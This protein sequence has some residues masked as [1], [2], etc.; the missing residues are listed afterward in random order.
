MN[1][2]THVFAVA[3]ENY[4]D[5]TIRQVTFAENDA[6]KFVE[7]WHALGADTKDC[8]LLLSTKATFKSFETRLKAFLS[9]V[10]TGDRVV[11]FFAGHGLAINAESRITVHDTD[12]SDLP[13]TTIPLSDI[14]KQ[15]RA[16]PSGQVL[17]FLDSCHS[18]LPINAGMRS[19]CSS[20]SADELDAFCKDSEYHFAFASCK[21]DQ[22]S[23][24]TS[25]LSHGIWSYC[26]LSALKG[27]VKAALE[28]GSLVTGNS[29]QT[30]VADEVPRILRKT[31]AGAVSQTPCAFGNHTKEFVVAD[32]GQILAAKAAKASTLGSLLKD[33]VLRGVAGGGVRSLT[34]FRKG[35]HREPDGHFRAAEKFVRDVGHEDV[36]SQ[37]E[38]MATAI[39]S[40][41]GY[42]FKDVD[43]ACN[44]GAA[45]I[46]TPDFDVN[47]WIQQAEDDAA[48]YVL[49]TD[50]SAIRNQA[51]V[52]EDNFSNVFSRY[53]DTVVIELSK[54]IGVVEKIGQIEDIKELN[55]HL[56]PKPDGSSFT[57]EL[58]SH[59]I[60]LHVTERQIMITRLSGGN[61]K[62]LLTKAQKGLIALGGA[63]V[64]L[65]LPAPNK[66]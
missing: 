48:A 33:S 56:D 18:G 41:F 63:G 39:K 61:L 9:H 3:V 38:E 62:T 47:L 36:K 6:T 42:K 12:R 31:I 14:L 43:F 13:G 11:F 10:A 37:A 2:R 19:I 53:C 35:S 32:V 57:L 30:Y 65:M 27:E 22:S 20:F 45:T 52:M 29:L 16:S 44:D 40:A 21:V 55:E 5:S 8:V 54:D 7:V 46:R 59:G 51:V 26:V 1:P 23:Y 49:T 15:M 60:R 28:K 4:Q 58:P 24:S 25:Q 34:G 66:P 17:L 50:V 64:L